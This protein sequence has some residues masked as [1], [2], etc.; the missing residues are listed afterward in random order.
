MLFKDT[1]E[2]QGIVIAHD[3]GNL[4]HVI[5][6]T[7]QEAYGVAYPYAENILHGRL[8]GDLLEVADKPADAHIA[9]QGVV[10][11]IYLLIVMLIEVAA[12]KLHLLLNVCAD[13]RGAFLTAAL[14]EQE[15]LPQIHGNKLLIAHAAA[16]KL[17]DYFLIQINIG[18][19]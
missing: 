5:V 14:D 3:G 10:L 18:R 6:R 11:N 7:L 17:R 19:G 2:I 4:S 1:A 13:C 15:Y 9:G 12:G 8:H 16:L